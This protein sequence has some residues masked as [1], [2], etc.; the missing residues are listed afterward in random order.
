MPSVLTLDQAVNVALEARKAGK[1]VVT[2][3]G[4]FDLLSVAHVRI[5]EEAKKHGDVL[6]VGVNSDAS[7]RSL[8]GEKRPVV[9]E[10]ERAS[11]VASL[12]SVDHVFLFDEQDPRAWLAKIKPNAHVNSAEYGEECIEA[13]VLK[14]IGAELILVPRATDILSTTERIDDIVRRFSR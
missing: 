11:L 13:S 10:Q 5:I 1:T 2:T 14:E 4:A 8:K 6:I 3:N 12:A 7:V 9:A